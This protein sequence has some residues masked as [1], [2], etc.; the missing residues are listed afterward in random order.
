MNLSHVF[1]PLVLLGC[2][3]ACLPPCVIRAQNTDLPFDSGST[4]VDGDLIYGDVGF[5]G[6]QFAFGFAPGVGSVRVGGVRIKGS[7]Q[8][9]RETWVWDDATW[10]RISST[11]NLPSPS[12][13]R[14]VN[15][16]ALAFDETAGE[17]LLFGGVLPGNAQYSTF[18]S[19]QTFRLSGSNWEA[20]SGSPNPAGRYRHAMVWDRA[21]QEIVL[22]GGANGS[23]TF[24]DTW[25]RSA[26]T[27]SQRSPASS[28]PARRNHV[29][30]YD[31]VR[32]EVVLFG[33]ENA[34]GTDLGD[35]WT[36]DGTD[37]TLE[38]PSASPS[39]RAEAA[40]AFDEARGK[41]VL[42][43]GNSGGSQTWTWD[44][45]NWTLE[46]PSQSPGSRRLH[47]MTYDTERERVVMAHA[48]SNTVDNPASLETWEWD[49]TDWKKVAGTAFNFDLRSK[50][51]AVWH[52][53]RIVIDNDVTV[54]FTP[55]AANTGVVWLA[56]ENV[57]ISGTLVL[58][59]AAASTVGTSGAGTA[60]PGGPGGFNG[61]L[62]GTTGGAASTVGGGPGGGAAG[63]PAAGNG[64]DAVHEGAYGT[65]FA[66]PLF[67][68]SGGGGG[69]AGS[70]NGY[71]GGSGGGA[72]LIAATG[73]ISVS[74]T[75]SARPGASG[76]AG[77]ATRGGGGHGS[78]GTVRLV[79][80]RILASSGTIDTSS[81]LAGGGRDGRIRLEGYVREVT[82]SN[83]KGST[84]ASVP[85]EGN[86]LHQGGSRLFITQVA[87]QG[88]SFQPTGSTVNPDV[89]FSEEGP[90]TITVAAA[91][92]PNGTPVTLTI[93]H[94]TTGTTV[95]PTVPLSNGQAVFSTTI[96]TGAGTLIASS[97]HQVGGD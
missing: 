44:G 37:W 90:V 95:L 11:G 70:A 53:S 73:D 61:G 20:V 63:A 21:R 5:G 49:G 28:P 42:Y 4:G 94:E 13:D 71:K 82:P 40:M 57:G 47:G 14:G 85:V 60:A 54:T 86:L 62:G 22:F 66:I 2:A 6:S 81:T 3:W 31:P 7:I 35:T 92:I 32:Q 30:A 17:L 68:G 48:Y 69:G 84:T 58:D 38:T 46:S 76:G 56:S 74:G 34:S 16:A 97:V 77:D 78:G 8:S 41:A 52:F 93:Q 55:N 19:N 10:S 88:V 96:A 18:Y 26:G 9:I 64:A 24:G 51:E 65:A 27:W 12:Y 89:V 75:I 25:V 83:L 67:G 29:M 36:W 23:T 15:Q 91:N 50:T 43:G 59:G 72:I 80:D 45:G 39:A 33:G 87:G 79:A 1:R